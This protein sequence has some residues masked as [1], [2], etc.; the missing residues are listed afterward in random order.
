MNGAGRAELYDGRTEPGLRDIATEVASAPCAVTSGSIPAWLS[1]SMYRQS[2]AAFPPP[3][4]TIGF[5]Y[6]HGLAHVAAV[7]FQ[8]GGA[9]M[10][11]AA[12]RTEA[13]ARWKTDGAREWGNPHEITLGGGAAA[14]KALYD[15]PNPNVTVWKVGE[16]TLAALSEAPRGRVILLDE[17]TLGTV[18]VEDMMDEDAVFLQAAH[19]FAEQDGQGFHAALYME[20]TGGGEVAFGYSIFHGAANRPP[21]TPAARLEV[22]RFPEGQPPGD[23]SRLAYMH[24]LAVTANYV[25]LFG[26]SRCLDYATFLNEWRA[27]TKSRV[28]FF[29]LWPWCDEAC[30]LHVFRRSGPGGAQL[31]YAGERRAPEPLLVWHTANAFEKGG[32]L[33][34]DVRASTSSSCHPPQCLDTRPL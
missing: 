32:R 10:T 13:H 34:V 24:T 29:Q 16:G 33:V 7:R 3:S 18:G 1:G 11:N 28:G 4:N 30:A 22:A 8:D 12:V 20:E 31:T 15:G 25:V 14:P 17:S 26:S 23:G 6:V 2:G 27:Q 9:H 5:A 19:F 21:L